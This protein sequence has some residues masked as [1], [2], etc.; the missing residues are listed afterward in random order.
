[1]KVVLAFALFFCASPVFAGESR[2]IDT[3]Y[4]SFLSH[5]LRESVS[6][7]GEYPLFWW[8]HIVLEPS[9]E[10]GQTEVIA[11]QICASLSES[12]AIA[13]TPC[14][15]KALQLVAE[16]WIADT[17][18]RKPFPAATFDRQWQSALA[19]AALPIPR[20]I[21]EWLRR[22]P[23]NELD[24]LRLRHQ[25]HGA[26]GFAQKD[27]LLFDPPTGRILIPVQFSHPPA[28]SEK[29]A[30]A[31]KVMDQLCL[32]TQCGGLHLIGPH[33]GT[34]ENEMRIR[35]D[36]NTVSVT[37]T[38]GLLLVVA[39]L[40]YT[41]RA[42]LLLLFPLLGVGIALAAA[43]TLAVFGRIHA[44]T[45]SFGPALIGLALDYGV[46]AA[47][48]D[49]KC[50]AT[51]RSNFMALIT[52]LVVMVLMAFSSVP[53]IRQMMFFAT[54]GLIIT[55]FLFHF[56]MRRSPQTFQLS[57]LLL[58]PRPSRPLGA[59]AIALSAATLLLVF[60]PLR[61]DLKQM[62][63]QSATTEDLNAWWMNRQGSE[64]P[65]TLSE[66]KMEKAYAAKAWALTYGV[67]YEG[68]ARDLPEPKV[69]E[70][71]RSTWKGFCTGDDFYRSELAERFFP[72]F[73]NLVCGERT[74][75]PAYLADFYHGGR[76]LNVLFA[77]NDAQAAAI[78]QHFP[79]AQSPREM[80]RRFPQTFARELKWML[81]TALI[82][83]L[84]FL[85]FYYRSLTPALLASLPFFSGTGL[86]ALMTLLLDLPVN[87]ISLLGL[88]L[89]FGFSIDY[90]IFAVDHFRS[91]EKEG[92][93]MWSALSF[94]A[95]TTM[96]GFAPLA[97]GQHPVL[98][99]LGHALLWGSVGTAI[100][101]FWGIPFGYRWVRNCWP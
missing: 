75:V 16:S 85:G 68:P 8:N 59:L 56:V 52:S 23:L 67:R 61:L 44:I 65:F 54:T 95:I 92:H 58:A 94:C 62:N 26:G 4:D 11:R 74:G 60:T 86:F 39:F 80:I 27:G 28:E 98:N 78:R 13:R 30:L 17:P 89:V 70:R 35:A 20:E 63:F 3:S 24:G 84:A 55:Y 57:P 96:A 22:D 40:L 36:L 43:L 15:A 77:A 101:A 87:F 79:E 82:L 64:T 2:W 1:M 7:Y 5:D 12:R 48:L 19:K 42:R 49:P 29:T 71:N 33:A 50:R 72:P 81:P 90:G 76:W 91:G 46:H 41:R 45:L 100:G 88:L 38:A 73:Q 99:S 6:H 10:S 14:H 31:M 9:A 97:F 32:K 47:F 25:S 53:L 69:Q 21:L 83:A 34:L 93:G 66:E 37:G 18:R 51:W